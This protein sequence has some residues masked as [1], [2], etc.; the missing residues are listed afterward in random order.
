[1]LCGDFNV[2]R[3]EKDVARPDAWAGTVLYHREVRD[4][5]ENLLAWGFVD[6]FRRQHPEGGLYPVGLPDVAPSR[7]TTVCDWTT[8]W[9]RHPWQ[10]VA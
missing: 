7:R 5:M 3:D 10:I 1:M 6:V 2:A 9:P 4:A 8:S